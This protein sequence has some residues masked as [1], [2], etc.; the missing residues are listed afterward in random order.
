MLT[1]LR[2]MLKSSVGNELT[3]GSNL[4]KFLWSCEP[5]LAPD[6]VGA[7]CVMIHSDHGFRSP[8][9]HQRTFLKGPLEFYQ[10][11]WANVVTDLLKL[12]IK[13]S[14]RKSLHGTVHKVL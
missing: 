3:L 1:C 4:N 11:N 13:V 2:N 7:T 14:N 5:S 10:T 6:L 9:R 12:I 8:I